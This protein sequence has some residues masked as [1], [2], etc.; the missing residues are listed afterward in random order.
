MGI[1]GNLIE[2]LQTLVREHETE[3]SSWN[4]KYGIGPSFQF[5]RNLIE[6]S[7]NPSLDSLT[8]E[9]EALEANNKQI[10]ELSPVIDIAT[11]FAQADPKVGNSKFNKDKQFVGSLDALSE[12]IQNLYA[13]LE[14]TREKIRSAGERLWTCLS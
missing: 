13:S 4:N 12:R 8:A 11:D 14:D 7:S 2:G 1:Q 3:I 6:V 9:V 5:I 10:E